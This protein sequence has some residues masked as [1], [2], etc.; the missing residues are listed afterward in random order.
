MYSGS[1]LYLAPVVGHHDKVLPIVYQTHRCSDG[2][3]YL[4]DN[5]GKQFFIS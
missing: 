1:W 2:V 3:A 5:M 4:E